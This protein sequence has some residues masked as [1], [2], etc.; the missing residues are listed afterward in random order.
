[1][2]FLRIMTIVFCLVAIAA[3]ALPAWKTVAQSAGTPLT[4]VEHADTDT[5]TDTGVKGDSVGD[6]LTFA[7][8]VYD[9]DNKAQ[10]GT[11]NGYCF[12]T[13]TGTAWECAWTLTLKDGQIMVQG[14]FYDASDSTL[15]ITGGT[16]TY[17][18]MRGEMKLHAR[19]EKG[20]EYDFTYTLVK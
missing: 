7:N 15:A 13:V 16:G 9:K 3:L 20:T 17:N 18:N 6:I 14:P 11:D 19:N 5:V 1:M 12:R 2:K 10:V 8:P 4:V